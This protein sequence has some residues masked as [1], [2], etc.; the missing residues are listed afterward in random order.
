MLGS[1]DLST[2]SHPSQWAPEAPG[3][4]PDL[5]GQYL[6]EIG[7]VALL[8]A[9]QELALGRRVQQGDQAAAHAL[10]QANLRLVVTVARRYLGHGL[11]LE[12]LIQ[13]GN[14]GLM[15]AVQRYD[16][17]LGYRFSTYGTWWIRQAIQRAIQRHGRT[18]RLPAHLQEKVNRLNRAERE[19]V[20]SLGREPTAAEVA[21]RSGL[22]P[23]RVSAL[24]EVAR[25]AVSLETPVGED[26]AAL[27][28]FVEDGGGGRPDEVVET[29]LM[30]SDLSGVLRRLEPR[31]QEVL[32]LRYGLKGGRGRTLQEVGRHLGVT[33]ERVRQIE[34][35]AL[36]RLRVAAE[37]SGLQDYLG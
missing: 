22:P 25:D 34:R 16:P 10:L 33:R 35:Q 28:H 1:P 3:G 18:I 30:E 4:E 12:D 2:Q 14:L 29:S 17:T 21:Q 19:L 5:V 37:A 23:R 32:A 26:E 9:E 24:R 36:N 13:E 27:G 11:S 31:E 7:Q 15:R 8:S 6:R 20:Q